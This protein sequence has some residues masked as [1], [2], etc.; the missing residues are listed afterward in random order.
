MQ[1]VPMMGTNL[2]QRLLELTLLS[3]HLT[4]VDLSLRD[5]QSRQSTM[6]VSGM[7]GK[8]AAADD[9]NHHDYA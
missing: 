6:S 2:F 7:I 1:Y 5:L 9:R 4:Y 8:Y 3:F